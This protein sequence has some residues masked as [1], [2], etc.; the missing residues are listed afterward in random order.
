MMPTMDFP[1]CDGSWFIESSSRF[2][3]RGGG[4]AGGGID[5]SAI[6]TRRTLQANG[7]Q[8]NAIVEVKALQ[9]EPAVLFVLS[10]P[11]IFVP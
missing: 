10:P 4:A 6:T 7:R 1:D 11:K 8:R 2:D 3:T 5:V 9:H